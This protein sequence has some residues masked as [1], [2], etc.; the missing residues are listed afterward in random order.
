[1]QRV[2]GYSL[3]THPKRLLHSCNRRIVVRL[4]P[5]PKTLTKSEFDNGIW[6]DFEGVRNS[7]P[8][9]AGIVIDG[10]FEFYII[11]SHL[12]KLEP[13]VKDIQF[14][15]RKQFLK[16]LTEISINQDRPI[17]G[18]GPHEYD[19]ILGED[20]NYAEIL[21]KMYR[22]ANKIARKHFKE[23]HQDGLKDYLKNPMFEYSYPNEFS[24]FSVTQT[25]TSLW[26][27]SR[28]VDS[29]QD[30]GKRKRTSLRKKLRKLRRYNE[31]DC[32]G[33]QHLMRIV[34]D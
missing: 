6:L 20:S 12:E 5:H 4:Y 26:S 1:M 21:N 31:H 22:N 25:I 34:V 14:M 3:T 11:D 2:L 8:A 9:F 27:Q 23:N 28:K 10:E 16:W 24:E 32:R 18:Y 33:M 15:E 19:M 17:I 29:F 13:V 7:P 30:L